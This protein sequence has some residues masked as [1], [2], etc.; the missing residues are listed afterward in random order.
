M[1]CVQKYICSAANGLIYRT[2]LN[3]FK[4]EFAGHVAVSCI[5]IYKNSDGVNPWSIVQNKFH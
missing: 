3:D 5:S 2:H 1:Q 4:A